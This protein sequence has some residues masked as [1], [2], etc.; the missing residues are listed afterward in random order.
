MWND[1]NDMNN[2]V[3]ERAVEVYTRWQW[4]GRVLSDQ[5]C[6]AKRGHEEKTSDSLKI[7]GFIWADD[8]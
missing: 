5:Q 8:E 3:Y 4:S 6:D 1:W 2:F 7:D